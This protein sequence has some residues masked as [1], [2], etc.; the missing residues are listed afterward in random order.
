MKHLNIYLILFLAFAIN[1]QGQENGIGKTLPAIPPATGYL[2]EKDGLFSTK[3]MS[4]NTALLL[5][6]WMQFKSNPSTTKEKEL[7]EKYGLIKKGGKLYANSFLMG[8][9]G[10]TT[11]SL[12]ELGVLPG[13]KSGDVFTAMLPV[14]LI[15]EI[16]KQPNVRY[17]D[18]GSVLSSTMDSARKQT[19][20]DKVHA[21]MAPLNMPYTGKGV[22]VGVID[23]GIDFTHPNFYDSTGQYNYR[24]K[25]VWNQ[26]DNSGVPPTGYAY[27]GE[28]ITEAQILNAK[29][30]FPFFQT[31]KDSDHGTHTAGIAA[32][33]GGY[34]GSP[35]RG[36]AY[37]SELVLVASK[38]TSPSIADGIKY[39]QAY[40]ASVGKPCVINMSLG[41]QSGPHDGTSTEDKFTDSTVGP[42]K[43]IVVA[44]G[45]DG[46]NPMY[47]DH[48]FVFTDTV[49]YTFP[50]M[51]KGPNDVGR[52][53]IWGNVNE[54]FAVRMLLYNTKTNKIEDAQMFKIPATSNMTMFDTLYGSNGIQAVVLYSTEI[55]PVN[56]KPH[57]TIAFVNT[58]PDST[59]RRVLLEVT[60]YNTSIQMWGQFSYNTW[61]TNLG[62]IA[63]AGI[64]N[65]ANLVLDGRTDY[66]VSDGYATG[67]SVITVGSYTT[68]NHW[69]SLYNQQA[70]LDIVSNTAV[71]N[72]AP[73]SSRGPTADGRTKPEITAP[74]NAIASSVNRFSTLYSPTYNS[75][76]KS[77]THGSDTWYFGTMSGTSMACPVV[78]GILALWLQKYPSLTREQALD[79]MK[80][81]AITD[82][83]TG[84]IPATG[85]NTWGWGKINAFMG[86]TL[87]IEKAAVKN[88]LKVYPNPAS[89]ELHIAF[90]KQANN[91]TINIA[92]ITGKIVYSNN[93]G[94]LTGG[95]EQI[96]NMGNNP[97]GIYILRIASNGEEAVY[98]IIK[99]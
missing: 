77:V 67:N 12:G 54:N 34:P 99:Q 46:I 91:T 41:G 47:I 33:S 26:F 90:D 85:S 23:Q 56:G 44:A 51:R 95:S 4:A 48:K 65:V 81:T 74:G 72:I 64:N 5:V 50:I 37:E 29:A 35:Y 84:T 30:D 31:N 97:A 53:N 92:D 83:Y 55:S 36:V 79:M 62:Y 28:Y 63:V 8:T 89:N 60:G 59:G 3:G 45:N 76:V 68:K 40:A 17:V 14:E 25:R 66:T 52:M 78:T 43:L 82:S 32:G 21:G 71:G 75:T 39:I 13:S 16:V 70:G 22:V 11:A 20:V 93:V 7:I 87:S 61:F 9:K 94:T 19:N 49:F 2:T 10:F 38:F 27:G 73:N 86:M 58:Q 96:V 42:G 98:K 80:K 6:D 88:T 15:A 69:I 57:I 24:V 1:A 18:I